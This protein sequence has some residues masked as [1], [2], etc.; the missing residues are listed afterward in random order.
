[1]DR[2][3]GQ[4]KSI[5]DIFPEY[6]R[7]HWGRIS[8]YT[9][10]LQEIRLRA[11]R[12]ILL[13]IHGKEWFLDPAG[14][15]VGERSMARYI[16]AEEIEDIFRHICSYSVYAFR[17]E[18]RQGFLTLPGGHR[19][20]L[21]GQVV[22]EDTGEGQEKR[23]TH[24]KHIRY[25]NIRIAHQILGAADEILP[26]LYEHG[27]LHNTLLIAPPCCGKTTMLRDLIRQ[28]SDGNRIA[29]GLNVAVVDERS[30]IAGSYLGIP[31][32]DIG[33]RTDVLDGCP[34]LIGI[35][36]LLRSMSP[37]VT[38]VDEIGSRAEAE[39]LMKAA[40]SGSRI[41]ATIHGSCLEEIRKKEFLQDCIRQNLFGRYIILQK[42]QGTYRIS[43]V[44]NGELQP[45]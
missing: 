5:I 27:E 43:G 30:E 26:L 23:I 37:R 35:M 7:Q 9:D 20:G 25:M 33:A 38:A 19:V 34:K 31:Q 14:V 32:N 41:L 1:M 4:K 40:Y 8:E 15:P 10:G 24:M 44:Y 11:G 17:E 29:P 3:S 42:H 12:E 13:Q 36:M 39:A 16:S 22:L 2:I 18:I 6:M 21:A 45:C 28:I